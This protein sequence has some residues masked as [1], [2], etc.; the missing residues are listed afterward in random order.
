MLEWSVLDDLRAKFDVPTLLHVGVLIANYEAAAKTSN[1][2]F[3]LFLQI[4]GMCSNFTQKS[5]EL[6]TKF[7]DELV[8]LATN[9]NIDVML[10]PSDK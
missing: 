8:L 9:Q 7:V 3:L 10:L 6:R 4:C 1:K 2:L 5:D